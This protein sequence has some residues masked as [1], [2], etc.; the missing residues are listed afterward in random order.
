MNNRLVVELKGEEHMSNTPLAEKKKSTFTNFLL[1]IFLLISLL[2]LTLYLLPITNDLS[3][4]PFFENDRPLVIAHQGGE[5]LAP[6]NTIVAFQQAVDMGVDVLETDIH[7]SKDGHLVAIH[8]PTVDRTTDGKGRVAD[9]TLDE[10]Q[11]LD[12]GHYFVDLEGNRSFQG[13]GVYIPTVE[14]LFQQFGHIRWE[15]EIKDDNP[16]ERMKEIAEKLWL[17]IEK[18]KMEDKV[19]IASFDQKIIDTFN[20]FAKNRVALAGG[21]QEI[22]KFVI[23]HKLMAR[24]AYFPKVDAF[25]IPRKNSG[26]DLTSKRLIRDA[27]RNGVHLHYWTIN[28]KEEMRR[29]LEN[30]ANGIITD[31]P[32]LLLELLEELGY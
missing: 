22:T 32:D 8:D 19:L 23:L 18:Y 7:I 21:R 3:N 26:I 12:A 1:F 29:L 16:P 15:I 9:M 5:H 31:R 2:F 17:L 6:S 13:Q 4:K 20:S 25:Q 30:G 10:L 14:E 24:N 27:N 11:Q 28:E